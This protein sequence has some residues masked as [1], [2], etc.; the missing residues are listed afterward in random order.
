MGI[1]FPEAA[2]RYKVEK[3]VVLRTICAYRKFTPVPFRDEDLRMGYLEETNAPYGLAK[4]ILLVQSL[5]VQ[6]QAYRPTV[7][8]EHHLSSAGESL[9]TRR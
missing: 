8:D 9:W 4:K 1:Q 2:R 7:R 5:L 3:T 6:S